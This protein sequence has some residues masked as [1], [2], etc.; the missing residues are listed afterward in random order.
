MEKEIHEYACGCV[1]EF[2]DTGHGKIIKRGEACQTQATGEKQK[3][4]H[5]SYGG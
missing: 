1:F 5:S 3:L 2:D 4:T